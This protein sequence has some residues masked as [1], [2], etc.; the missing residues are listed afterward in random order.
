MR[1]STQHTTPRPPDTVHIEAIKSKLNLSLPARREAT[2]SYRC[3]TTWKHLVLTLEASSFHGS[4]LFFSLSSL[5][6]IIGIWDYNKSHNKLF[7]IKAIG[8]F[9]IFTGGRVQLNSTQ[10]KST[11]LNQLNSTQP[12]LSPFFLLLLLPSLF[13]EQLTAQQ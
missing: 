4:P 13:I 11:Q 1:N 10:P 9:F 8:T 2:R 3:L 12:F 7:M 5:L 6:T